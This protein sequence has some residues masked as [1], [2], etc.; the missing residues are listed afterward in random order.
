VTD[1]THLA[2]RFI[3]SLRAGGPAPGDETWARDQL[4]PGERAVW[5]RM[6]GTD[7]RHAVAVARTAADHLGAAATRP[8]LAA[9]L[10]HDAGKVESGL[11][12]FQ[13]VVAT[14]WGM[15]R[16]RDRVG[17]RFRAYLRHDVLGARLLTAAGSDPLTVTWAA[18]HHLPP[19]RWTLDPRVATALKAADDD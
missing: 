17:G 10:L 3:G 15:A 6:S 18:E 16:G 1:W 19:S 12:T 2:R 13:R 8:V 7:R 11:G 4:A 5:A 9:A 14:L